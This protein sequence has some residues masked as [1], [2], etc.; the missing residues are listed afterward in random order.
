MP[1]QKSRKPKQNG[2]RDFYFNEIEMPYAAPALNQKIPG[3]MRAIKI[4][5]PKETAF[6]IS[7]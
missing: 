7:A 4:P 6:A 1:S 3:M 2:L 5:A